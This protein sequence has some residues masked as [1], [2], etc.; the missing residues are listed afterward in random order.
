MNG[1]NRL[2]NANQLRAAEAA[3]RE[4]N[5]LNP[6]NPGNNWR[7]PQP[8]DNRNFVSKGLDAYKKVP[9]A[10]QIAHA[11]LN[12]ITGIP[13]AIAAN[14]DAIGR[15]IKNI[16][17]KIYNAPGNVVRSIGNSAKKFGSGVA[18]F[19]RRAIGGIANMFK[20]RK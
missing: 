6:P 9:V 4:S 14:R 3:R 11:V 2:P 10:G 20:W 17:R 13:M 15:G 8:K 18:N 5:Y 16:G 1:M 7:P 12:P 19:G